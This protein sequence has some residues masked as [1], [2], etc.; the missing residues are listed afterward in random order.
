LKRR[1]E[2][3]YRGVFSGSKGNRPISRILRCCTTTLIVVYQ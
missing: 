3:G 1:M 2:Q